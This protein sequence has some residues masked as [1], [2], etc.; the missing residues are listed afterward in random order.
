MITSF[1]HTMQQKWARTCS[2]Y[3]WRY[4]TRTRY[5]RVLG[6]AADSVLQHP[7]HAHTDMDTSHDPLPQTLVNTS[8][9]FPQH[10]TR[11][12]GPRSHPQMPL[13]MGPALTWQPLG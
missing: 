2:L 6:C 8:P 7:A 4:D 5:T 13:W 3:S 12:E 9:R 10:A 11:T 1:Q